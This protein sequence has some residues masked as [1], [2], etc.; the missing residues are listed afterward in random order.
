MECKIR[1]GL[2]GLLA[3]SM[4]FLSGFATAGEAADESRK[5]LTTAG[6]SET[7]SAPANATAAAIRQQ[8]NPRQQISISQQYD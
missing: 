5:D 3:G 2:T 6:V 7:P 8:R 1:K 4:L